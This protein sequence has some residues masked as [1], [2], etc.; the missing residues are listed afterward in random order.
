MLKQKNLLDNNVLVSHYRQ[1]NFDLAQFITDGPLCH[2][3]DIEDCM[4]TYRKNILPLNGVFY[5]F[6]KT[7][8]E[9]CSIA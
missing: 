6:V 7:Q 8:F 5:W 2:C 3:D 1:R 9:G 4:Q